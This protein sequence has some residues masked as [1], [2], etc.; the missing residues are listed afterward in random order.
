MSKGNVR[1]VVIVVE[2]GITARDCVGVICCN[3]G[4]YYKIKYMLKPLK[5][6]EL[7]LNKRN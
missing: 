5:V 6:M 1:V 7:K 3:N 2:E 4:E